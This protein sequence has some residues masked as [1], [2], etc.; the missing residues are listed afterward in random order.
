MKGQETGRVSASRAASAKGQE[1]GCVPRASVKG[2]ET[3]RV[4]TEPKVVG[5][6]AFGIKKVLS[7]ATSARLRASCRL[8]LEI[9]YGLALLLVSFLPF[10]PFPLFFLL[11]LPFR[12]PRGC[13]ALRP[14]FWGQNAPIQ[15]QENL[16]CFQLILILLSLSLLSLSPSLPSSFSS[17]SSSPSP[18][19]LS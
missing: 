4:S 8:I 15:H 18:F 9:R 1:T 17:S 7:G 3:G 16:L 14:T 13:V 12:S 11:L 5:L 10:L 6:C 2:Q 19:S